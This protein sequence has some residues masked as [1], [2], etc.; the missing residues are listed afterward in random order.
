MRN[1]RDPRNHRLMEWFGGKVG[2]FCW[3]MFQFPPVM[4]PIV[5]LIGK[6]HEKNVSR[7]KSRSQLSRRTRSE[8]IHPVPKNWIETANESCRRYGTQASYK[9]NEKRKPDMRWVCM[10]FETNYQRLGPNLLKQYPAFLYFPIACTG[11]RKRAIIN[12]IV[13]KEYAKKRELR[14]EKRSHADCLATA[15]LR[16]RSCQPTTN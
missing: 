9:W 12:D 14:K 13:S 11:N 1:R 7:Q 2:L 8:A 3:D 4:P 16:T 10:K 5:N 15:Y 6:Q